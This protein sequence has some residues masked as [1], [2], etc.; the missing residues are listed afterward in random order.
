MAFEIF[1]LVLAVNAGLNAQRAAVRPGT[2]LGRR[3]A[4]RRA[5]RSTVDFGRQ[6]AAV[7][8]VEHEAWPVVTATVILRSRI[9]TPLTIVG[10]V[11][12]DD[13]LRGVRV[14]VDRRARDHR[15][16]VERPGHGRNRDREAVRRAVVG[17]GQV[18]R[19]GERERRRAGSGE[20]RRRCRSGSPLGQAPC[21]GLRFGALC[22]PSGSV[23]YKP[24]R[25]RRVIC[26]EVLV[27]FRPFEVEREGRVSCHRRCRQRRT[28]SAPVRT[29]AAMRRSRSIAKTAGA[30]G[31]NVVARVRVERRDCAVAVRRTASGLATAPARRR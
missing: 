14:D 12:V 7:G 15:A 11:L 6:R 4:S 18:D 16:E 9:G 31:M 21:D 25:Q 1:A 26:R 2:A 28:C 27:A 22:R 20:H 3:R 29:A 24:W 23:P 10:S 30:G 13:H 8:R 19:A 17:P 5:S